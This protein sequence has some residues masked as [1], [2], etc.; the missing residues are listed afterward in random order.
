[1][2][3]Y[4][5]CILIGMFLGASALMLIVKYAP[6]EWFKDILDEDE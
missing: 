4:I 1:M 6:S 5:V 3:G 2:F